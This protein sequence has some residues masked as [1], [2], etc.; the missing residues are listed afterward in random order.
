MFLPNNCARSVFQ[1]HVIHIIHCLFDSDALFMLAAVMLLE[2]ISWDTEPTRGQRKL[3]TLNLTSK[4][5]AE[6]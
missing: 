1:G 6:P 3:W 5:G 2:Q 4:P